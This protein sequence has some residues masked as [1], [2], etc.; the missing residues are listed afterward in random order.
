MREVLS[1]FLMMTQHYLET[2]FALKVGSVSILLGVDEVKVSFISLTWPDG[3][4]IA[5]GRAFLWD[6]HCLSIIELDSAC[7]CYPFPESF[8]MDNISRVDIFCIDGDN[9][10]L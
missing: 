7:I 1:L 6:S 8:R 9:L 3:F 5:Q 4:L 2:P 10:N